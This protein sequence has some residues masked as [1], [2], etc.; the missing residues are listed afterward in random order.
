MVSVLI[1]P[2]AGLIGIP[3]SRKRTSPQIHPDFLI[4][5]NSFLFLVSC[6]LYLNARRSVA[7]VSRRKPQDRTTATAPNLFRASRAVRANAAKGFRVLNHPLTLQLD[8]SGPARAARDLR[9]DFWRG[10][11]LLDMVLV[12]LVYERVNFGTWLTPVLGEYVRFAA[13]GFIFM[14][15]LGVGA[16][17]LPRARNPETRWRTYRS[18]GRRALYILMVHIA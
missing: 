4:V 3:A 6:Q 5:T 15:G 11:C 16:I 10:L 18:L 8:R 13:G 9:L 7:R 2:R 17:F 14:A 1:S 12:H